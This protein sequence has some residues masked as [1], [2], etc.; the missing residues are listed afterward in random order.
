M[1]IWFAMSRFEEL[2][3]QA[4]FRQRSA[5]LLSTSLAG[6]VGI[7]LLVM[8]AYSRGVQ[9]QIFPEQARAGATLNLERGIGLAVGHTVYVFT[10]RPVVSIIAPRYHPQRLTVEEGDTLSVHLLPLPGRLQVTVLPDNLDILWM[11]NDQTLPA[12][13]GLDTALPA[14][15]HRLSLS[16]PY[17]QS[18]T[19]DLV[20][21]A[22]EEEELHV[23]LEPVQGQIS[24]SSQPEQAEVWLD[25]EA[26]GHTP[27]VL[28]RPGGR[29][30]V[31]LHKD[32]YAAIHDVLEIRQSALEVQRDYRLRVAQGRI[33]LHLVPSDGVLTL[34]NIQVPLKPLLE[35]EAGRPHSLRYAKSGYRTEIVE[36]TVQAGEQRALAMTLQQNFG[37]VTIHSRPSGAAV[38]HRGQKVGVTPLALRLPAVA[39]RFTLSKKGYEDAVQELVLD[40]ERVQTLDTVLVRVHQ[41]TPDSYVHEAGG[42]LRLFNP[43]TTFLMGAARHEAGQRANER[44]KEVRLSRAFYA[45]VHEVSVKEYSHFRPVQGESDHPVI[46]IGWTDAVKFCNW[47]SKQENLVPFYDVDVQGRMRGNPQSRGYRLLSEAE[48]EWLAR[49]AGKKR[50]SDFPWGNETVL[51]PKVE[52]VAD[53]SARGQVKVFIPGYRDGYSGIAPVGRF[54]QGPSGLYDLGGNVSEWTHD[55][56]SAVPD[57]SADL[58]DNP[59]GPS[60]GQGHVVK[61]ANWRSGTLTA[62][63]SAFRRS[64]LQGQDDL[65]FRIGR[66]AE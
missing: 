18:Y 48:W 1:S 22:A 45:G 47:L 32:G 65:G 4:K 37:R 44:L 19:H 17:Y 33:A 62:L 64:G 30:A 25:G 2:L 50:R 35:V 15:S 60:W 21:Q 43:Q 66:Y 41:D 11:L 16:H 27:L 36:L 14:G 54:T 49:K 56:Y 20:L 51:P 52:N 61:G 9:V 38:W 6:G 40:E 55:F 34:N 24:L 46:G 5:F 53:E 7:L 10:A 63:R 29:Y 59:L 23:V 8:F 3:K 39:H 28:E 31:Q 57:G 58:A 42:M 13:S 26:V 12:A